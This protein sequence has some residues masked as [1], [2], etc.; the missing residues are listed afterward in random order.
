MVVA[1][2]RSSPVFTRWSTRETFINRLAEN[3]CRHVANTQAHTH[4][5]TFCSHIDKGLNFLEVCAYSWA[6]RCYWEL[7]LFSNG[8]LCSTS[9][10]PYLH[11]CSFWASQCEHLPLFRMRWLIIAYNWAWWKICCLTKSLKFT[12][13][14]LLSKMCQLWSSYL[15]LKAKSWQV[16]IKELYSV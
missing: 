10:S 11:F 13:V 16:L 9:Q 12:C 3:S 5:D 7:V 1:R 8:A 2:V 6:C 15:M 14:N 4:N